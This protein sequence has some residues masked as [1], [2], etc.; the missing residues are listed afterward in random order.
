MA[1]KAEQQGAGLGPFAP[2]RLTVAD[3]ERAGR[4]L[5]SPAAPLVRNIDVVPHWTGDADVFWYRK[6]VEDG[7]VFE[8]IDPHTLARKPA[9]DH[10]HVATVLA[11]ASGNP[12]SAARLPFNAFRYDPDGAAIQF[13]AFG[14]GWTCKLD[15]PVC[16][17][18]SKPFQP[19]EAVAPDGEKA[20]LRRDRNLWLRTSAGD[21][22]ALTTDGVKFDEYGHVSGDSQIFVLIENLPGGI[23]PA[24]SWSPDS[25]CFLTHRTD[26]RDV[27]D[28][29]LWQGAPSGSFRAEVT[30]FK[31]SH[32]VDTARAVTRLLIFDAATGAQ[33][34]VTGVP[35][36]MLLDPIGGFGASGPSVTEWS[37]DSRAVY[38]FARDSR[39]R[40]ATLLRVDAATGKATPIIEESSSTYLTLDGSHGGGLGV[41]LRFLH[42]RGEILW[43]SERDGWGHLYRY[44]LGSGRLLNRVTSGPWVVSRIV[45]FD[46]DRGVIYLLGAGREKGRNPYL[47]SLYRVNIDGS[48]LRLLTAEDAD[49]A[50]YARRDS[51]QTVGGGGSKISPSM[52]YFVD[53]YSR[54]DTVPVSVL[55][56]TEDGKVLLNL[57]EAEFPEIAANGG[58]THP[59]PFTVKGRDGTT[60]IHGTMY[61][62]SDFDAERKYAVIDNVYPAAHFIVPDVQA[63]SQNYFYRQQ[64][65]DLGFIVVNMDGLGTP[66]RGKA[67]HDF[68]YGNLQDG[69]GLADH[70]AGIRNLAVLY[71]QI[72]LDRVGIHGH[73]SGGYGTVLAMLKFPEFYKVGVASAAPLNMGGTIPMGLEKWHGLEPGSRE[74]CEPIIL[75]NM[76]SNL[77]GKLLLAY[78]DMDEHAPP[79][80]TIQFIEALTRANR[81][82]DLLVMA[83]RNHMFSL[84]PYFRRRLIDYF[85]RNLL[86]AE[87]PMNAP[88]TIPSGPQ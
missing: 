57:E 77:R 7:A 45:D 83:N 15:Q 69:P 31:Q 78:A 24:I 73:S 25:S 20:I 48:D 67:F 84:D 54:V 41:A 62:P 70:V 9:F 18:V 43:F 79:A 44:D 17:R 72:D 30:T 38:V 34:E 11:Q 42:D 76:A 82:Y 68:S 12:V 63:F 71:P 10:D 29:T 81:D 53:S 19:N 52:R 86:G 26:E 2:S 88:L 51:L 74:G 39:H 60:D 22:R 32:A 16:E 28:A 56:S 65:A 13:D 3:Y 1:A 85:V 59:V 80:V 66:G 40:K 33:V 55:R 50:V 58:W 35:D 6:E 47:N 4:F 14:K 61:L 64:I 49:H 21:E 23:P 27:S 36:D 87:P 8:L 37:A 5:T 75:A 46:N